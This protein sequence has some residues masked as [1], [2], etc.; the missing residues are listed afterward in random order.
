MAEIETLFQRL[1][2]KRM[3]FYRSLFAAIGLIFAASLPAFAQLQTTPSNNATFLVN[4]LIGPG[5]TVSNATINTQLNA[6]G[7]FNSN[8]SNIGLPGGV[9]LTSGEVA[10]AIG[11]NIS[12]GI[13][14]SHFA[15]GDPLLDLLAAPFQTEDAC[16]LEF[17]M[18][19][20][21]DTIQI[22]YVFGS[23]EYDEYVCSDFTDVFGFFISGPGIVGTQNIAVIPGTTTPISINTVNIGAPG[24]FANFPLPANCNTGNATYFTTN[25][26]GTTVEYDG[27]TVPLIA[28]SAVIPCSTYHIKLAIADAG[29]DALDSGVF[30]EQGGIRC[31]ATSIAVSS[32]INNPGYTN[33]IEG[34]VSGRFTFVRSG[35]TTVA[36]SFN[37]TVSGTATPGFD[38]PPL[39]GVVNF[40]PMVTTA[41]INVTATADGLPEGTESVTVILSN[42]L[43]AVT[44]TDSATLFISDQ[45]N[46]SAGP[47]HSVCQGDTIQIGVLPQPGVSYTWLPGTSLSNPN[48]SNPLFHNPAVGTYMLTLLGTDTSGCQ[49]GDSMTVTVIL[50][51]TATFTAPA[52]LCEGETATITYTGN[53]PANATYNWSFGGGTI[54]SG[55]GQGPYVIDWN[56]TGPKN[57]SLTVSQGGCSSLPETFTVNVNSKPALTLG[58][59]NPTCF[60]VPNGSVTSTVVGGTP[61][62]QYLW[63][64]GSGAPSLANLPVGTYSL[65]ITD[66]MGCGD[67]ASVT[68]TEPSLLTS[69]FLVDSIICFGGTG[70]LTAIPAGG[71]Q[72]YSILWSTSATSTSIS[73]TLGTYAVTITDA[74]G[75]TVSQSFTLTEPPMVTLDISGD[76]IACDYEQVTLNA[77]LGGGV[78][79]YQYFWSSSPAAVNDSTASITIDADQDRTVILDITDAQGCPGHATIFVDAILRPSVDFRPDITQ[80]C[81]SATVTFINNTVPTNCSYL[82]EFQDGTTSTHASPQ[83]WFGNGVW[84]ASLTAT[85]P[86][87]CVNAW[88][89]PALIYII[90]TPEASFVSDPQINLVDYL[91]LS[92]ATITFNNTS[93]WYAQSVDWSFGNGDSAFVGQVTYTYPESGLFTV[94]MTAYNAYGCHDDTSQTFLILDDPAMWVPTAFTPNGDGLN[95][96][97]QI[98]GLEVKQFDISIFDRWGKLIFRSADIS[99]SWDGKIDGQ[100]ATEGVYVYKIDAVVNTGPVRRQGSVTVIR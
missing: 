24:M 48:I 70:T 12:T 67:T 41:S 95:D 4:Q 20:T 6:A 17:D 40:P 15:P 84:G 13:S 62:I 51:P 14:T 26:T 7:T 21:C 2:N 3:T 29:D 94:T 8:G 32:S 85:S 83:H 77:V 5:I 69:Q 72:P 86:E 23:D 58:S 30:L 91:L 36:Q 44:T 45:I 89:V 10:N 37:Y 64:I 38:Y 31:T 92:E 1:K 57:I 46:I 54:V 82:W 88:N 78:P 100:D 76:S 97:F 34:C 63:N 98:S 16:V 28:K 19:A 66:A 99:N 55:S 47:S 11:P 71:T 61:T 49:G 25:N 56:T 79:P 81:D 75:C 65:T 87:G 50:S 35:D 80:A 9:L 90:P 59:T 27:F 93:P 18:V 22:S 96:V 33:A 68:L 73:P 43:C 53:A 74:Q 39:S 60:G 52:N 42:S